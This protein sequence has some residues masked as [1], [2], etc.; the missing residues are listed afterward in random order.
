VDVIVAS[1]S[2]RGREE[3]HVHRTILLDPRDFTHK[4]G[5]AITTPARTL[6]DLASV[7]ST[8]A[9]ERAVAE[10]MVLKLVN[11]RHL[12]EVIARSGRHPG[13]AALR[14]AIAIGPDLTRS[15]AERIFRRLVKAAGLPTPRANYRIGKWEVDFYFPSK[16]VVVEIDGLGPHGT[17]KAF[18]QD[19]RKRSELTA[20]GY[21]VLAFTYKQ[22][23]DDP[24]WVVA[25]V[26]QALSRRA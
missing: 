11:A 15:E 24:H 19:R 3:V 4:D 22:L 8:Y 21:T 2:H 9:L 6:L 5:F 1:G 26:A 25:Q 16:S 13:A 20:A 23:T 12:N 10:A 17:P 7:M 14:R 18:E